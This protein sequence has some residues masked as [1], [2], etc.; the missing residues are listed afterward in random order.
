MPV[1]TAWPRSTPALSLDRAALTRLIEPAFPGQSVVEAQPAEGG[2]AN[3]NI[4]V[5]LSETAQPVLV[6]L[7]VRS[8]IEARKEAALHQLVAPTVPV[9]R[10]FYVAEHNPISGH[11]YALIEWVDGQRLELVAH[12]LPPEQAALLGRSIGATM[13]AIHTI[14]FAQ[15]GFLAPDL[16]IAQPISVGGDA[17]RAFLH[18]CLVEG[19]GG[20]R[21]G[22]E[23]TEALLAF[24]AQHAALLD[25]WHGPACLVHGDFGGSNILVRPTP[26]GFAVAAVLDW[27]FALSGSPF[28]DLGNLLRPPL[29]DVA[30]FEQGVYDGYIAAG[31][32]LPAQWR[33][34]A[35]LIDLLSWADF[36]NR[37][38]TNPILVRHAQMIIERTLAAQA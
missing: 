2:L 12:E 33:Q 15:T 7:Y 24:V 9:P 22:A 21:L 19:R 11:P 17:L 6:R 1:R 30:G 8:P 16:Q 34:M 3:T 5:R 27:E 14:T 32:R 36:M 23:L 25:R 18:T 31:G 20:A 26:D 38:V 4:R 13:A 10:F 29:E 35:R 37:P 28:F